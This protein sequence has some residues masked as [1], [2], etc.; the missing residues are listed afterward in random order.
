MTEAD[1]QAKELELEG[2][3]SAEAGNID[4]ALDFFN[5]AVTTAPANPSCYN[6]RAQALRLKGDV[7]GG[8]M[9][10]FECFDTGK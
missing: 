8:Y 7:T 6:N 4:S 1:R 3:K 5:K 10:H 2:V 9:I